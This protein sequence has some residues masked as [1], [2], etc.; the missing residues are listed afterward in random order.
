MS[1]WPREEVPSPFY[2]G[3]SWAVLKGSPGTML[4]LQAQGPEFGPSNV[5]YKVGSM[6]VIR[7]PVPL[8]LSCC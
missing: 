6:S 3:S 2:L 7:L 1:G 5:K 8:M 4:P